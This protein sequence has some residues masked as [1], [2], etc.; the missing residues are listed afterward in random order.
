MPVQERRAA[1]ITA[2][3]PRLI[4]QGPSVST[5]D[6]AAAAG[7]AEGTLFRV[8]ETKDALIDA[9]VEAALDPEPACTEIRAV[10]PGRPLEQRLAAAIRIMHRRIREVTDLMMA[11]RLRH[12]SRS[13]ADMKG[14]HAKQMERTQTMLDAIMS[15]LGDDAQQMRTSPETAARYV[16]AMTFLTG[17][18]MMQPDPVTDIDDLVDVM[19]HGLTK[20]THTPPPQEGPC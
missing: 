4:E 16:W 9:A 15:L 2:A 19:L 1:I 8:F 7:I 14:Q 13:D 11:M 10:D 20:T 18:P 12:G 17:H 6:V 5:R 3:I